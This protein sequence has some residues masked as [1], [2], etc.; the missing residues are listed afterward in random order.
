MVAVIVAMAYVGSFHP[1]LRL[2]VAAHMCLD[3]L[4]WRDVRPP[5]MVLVV[6]CFMASAGVVG[7]HTVGGMWLVGYG[8]I[9]MV[10]KSAV[11]AGNTGLRAVVRMAA[12]VAVLWVMRMP[13]ICILLL[14]LTLPPYYYTKAKWAAGGWF[15]ALVAMIAEAALLPNAEPWA[16]MAVYWS[17]LAFQYDER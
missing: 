1:V 10:L 7:V 6:I 15:A 13:W 3:H 5:P 2:G 12:M 14:P 17:A 11:Y 9:A 4:V 8:V 16:Y